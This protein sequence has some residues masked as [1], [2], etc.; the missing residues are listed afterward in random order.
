MRRIAHHLSQKDQPGIIFSAF[1]RKKSYQTILKDDLTDRI[2]RSST[3]FSLSLNY[4]KPYEMNAPAVSD[5]INDILPGDVGTQ[6]EEAIDSN[7]ASLKSH[8]TW[9]AVLRRK[10]L[11]FLKPR[12]MFSRILDEIRMYVGRNFCFAVRGFLRSGAE[13]TPAPA[14]DF[15]TVRICLISSTQKGTSFTKSMSAQLFCMEKLT[16]IFTCTIRRKPNYSE[17]IRF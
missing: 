7:S 1:G 16:K 12:V 11:L 9:K 4:A 17:A 15:T 6:W 14:I 8:G 3:T 10:K 13:D 2:S 5:N